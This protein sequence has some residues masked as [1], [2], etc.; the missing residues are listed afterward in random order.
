MKGWK[1]PS[2]DSVIIRDDS[3][4]SVRQGQIGDCY[5]ISAIGVLGKNRINQIISPANESPVG[6]HMVKFNKLNRDLYVII[7]NQY[8]V[9]NTAQENQWLFGRC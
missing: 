3:G 1:R 7:D 5:L 9:Y 2:A 4:M 8:P 6:A